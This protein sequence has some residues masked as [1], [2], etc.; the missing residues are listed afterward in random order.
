MPLAEDY[1]SEAKGNFILHMATDPA[2]L[3]YPG[4]YLRDTQCLSEKAQVAYDRIMCEHMRNI[5]ITQQQLNFFIKKLNDEE[6]QEV[7][8]TLKKIPGGFQIAWVAESIEKRR[9]YSESRRKNKLGKGK[10]ISKSYDEHMENEIENEDEIEIK[11]ENAKAENFLIPKMIAEFK[12]F[13]PEYPTDKTKDYPALLSIANFIADKSKIPKTMDFAFTDAIRP[14]WSEICKYTNQD[15]FFKNYSISQ[16]NK[17][18][19]S[20]VLNIQNGTRNNS[21]GKS[22]TKLTNSDLNEAHAK[23]FGTK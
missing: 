7:I 1:H 20:I 6:K 13:N 12:K 10:N 3:F 17:H 2:F 23:V 9:V 22:G 14:F 21:N 19:Q 4:D 5:C 8:I 18:I 16:I 11:K 15:N